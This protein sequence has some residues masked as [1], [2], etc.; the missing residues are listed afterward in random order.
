VNIMKW[1]CRLSAVVAIVASGAG[2]ATSG[3]R[4]NEIC[5][6]GGEINYCVPP[7]SEPS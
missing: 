1:M 5:V 7:E 3:D 6:I 4:V 2:L